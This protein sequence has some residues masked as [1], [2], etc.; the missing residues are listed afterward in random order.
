MRVKD[1]SKAYGFI[2]SFEQKHPESTLRADV[3]EQWRK[4]SR[5]KPGEWYD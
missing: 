2:D 4:G 5:G 3:I 1:K